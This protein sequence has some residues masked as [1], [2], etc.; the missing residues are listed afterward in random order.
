MVQKRFATGKTSGEFGREKVLD[1]ITGNSDEK[2][3]TVEVDR[4]CRAENEEVVRDCIA[5]NVNVC[6]RERSDV[7]KIS[8]GFMKLDAAV[9]EFGD[10]MAEVCSKQVGKDIVKKT[11]CKMSDILCTTS[12]SK[13]APQEE[14]LLDDDPI[15]NDENFLATVTTLEDAFTKTSN[16]YPISSPNWDL[17]TPT[18]NTQP[19]QEKT[20]LD[21]D[22]FLTLRNGNVE[23]AIVDVWSLRMNLKNITRGVS[24][25]KCV[26]HISLFVP[27][28][29]QLSDVNKQKDFYEKLDYELQLA[30]NLDVCDANLVFFPILRQTVQVIDN[31]TLGKGVTYAN[32][33]EQSDI[34]L[35][36]IVKMFWKNVENVVDCEVYCM[37]HLETYKGVGPK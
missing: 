10:V 16:A 35:H 28:I 15:F 25:P 19:D 36:E 6:E 4:D 9:M 1:R 31:K 23:K 8:K 7:E 29:T 27:W 26:H 37:R 34:L 21:K 30:S 33:Y 17:L 3:E 13:P 12:S 2:V 14:S 11:F 20:L 24:S 18:P 22:Q 32:K 5:E